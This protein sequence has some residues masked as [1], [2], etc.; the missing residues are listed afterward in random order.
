MAQ[1]LMGFFPLLACISVATFE[2]RQIVVGKAEIPGD[3]ELA[4]FPTQ[5]ELRLPIGQ[6]V[7]R[8]HPR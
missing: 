4:S 8:F 5:P 3:S 6:T 7:S 1:L 2:A